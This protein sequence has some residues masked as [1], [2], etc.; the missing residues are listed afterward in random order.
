MATSR[1]IFAFRARFSEFTGVTDADIAAV[2]DTA[3]VFLDEGAW[4]VGSPDFPRAK[5]YFAAHMMSLLQTTKANIE[6]GGSGAGFSDLF[7]RQIRI[8]ERAMGFGQ[9]QA[10]NNASEN[11]GPGD[12]MLDLTYYG[13]LYE[14]LRARNFP[15]VAIV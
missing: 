14:K 9:R 5:E 15:A 6:T 12:M 10:F 4:D 11:A 8:G 1:D 13:Q 7:V 3:D 2:L